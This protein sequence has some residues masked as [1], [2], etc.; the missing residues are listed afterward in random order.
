[1]AN[2]NKSPK[3]KGRYKGK[4]NSNPNRNSGRGDDRYAARDDKSMNRCDHDCKSGDGV[5]YGLNDVGWYTKN[6]NLALAAGSFP[7]P[8]RPGMSIGLGNSMTG[9]DLTTS[10]NLWIPGV[11]VMDWIPYIGDA[12]NSLSPA[13]I[14]AKEIYSTVRSKF[15]SSLDAEPADFMVYEFAL[16]SVFAALGYAKRILRVASV[17]TP[18]N[19][20]LPDGLLCAMGFTLTECEN[21]RKNKTLYWNMLNQAILSSRKF[22][23]PAVMDLYNRHYWM[24]DNVYMDAASPASQFYLFNMKGMYQ[25][26]LVPAADTSGNVVPGLVTVPFTGATQTSTTPALT[27]EGIISV[28]NSCISALVEWDDAYTISGYLMRAYEGVPSFSVSE[29]DYNEVLTPLYIEE[30][31]TQIENSTAIPSLGV[32]YVVPTVDTT[33]AGSQVLVTSSVTQDARRAALVTSAVAYYPVADYNLAN[34]ISPIDVKY[35]L[36][37]INPTISIRSDSPTVADSI[38]ATR[39]KTYL[40]SRP[41]T[42]DTFYR[43][44]LGAATEIC[45]NW[46]VMVHYAAAD[47]DQWNSVTYKQFSRITQQDTKVASYYGLNLIAQFIVEQF[48]WHPFEYIICD[49]A[50]ANSYLP[51]TVIRGDIHNLTVISQSDLAELNKVCVLSELNAY[52]Y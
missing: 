4:R 49:S 8:Y 28:I 21:I 26:Q 36:G 30:V 40:T 24:S 50:I 25:F 37:F 44:N 43:V 34:A 6:P 9:T 13:A 48:D 19:R 22:M 46:R 12:S 11:M 15:S 32:N 31:L 7:F 47:S 2:N 27:F 3:N 29:F 35:G 45:L 52:N 18:E 17:W 51:Q 14:A 39:L 16:D 33:K 23:C 5:N 41:V 20:I 10:G 42:K 1:M 38:I